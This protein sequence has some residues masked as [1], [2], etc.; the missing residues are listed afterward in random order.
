MRSV[1]IPPEFAFPSPEQ[2]K[3]RARYRQPL[4][5]RASQ[6]QSRMNLQ[7]RL[8]WVVTR[9]LQTSLSHQSPPKLR[10]GK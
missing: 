4:K 6:V 1:P 9:R 3:T 7:T 2:R 10:L 8:L 5:R